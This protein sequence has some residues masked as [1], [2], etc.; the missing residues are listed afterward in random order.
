MVQTLLCP[1][2]YTAGIVDILNQGNGAKHSDGSRKGLLKGVK[3]KESF[4]RVSLISVVKATHWLKRSVFIGVVENSFEDVDRNY[5]LE[6]P[7]GRF[8]IFFFFYSEDNIKLLK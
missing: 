8:K 7:E 4:Q 5:I 6:Y 1:S 3:S 2:L